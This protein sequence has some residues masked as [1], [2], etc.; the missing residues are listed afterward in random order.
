MILPLCMYYLSTHNFGQL[1]P[2]HPL[3]TQHHSFSCWMLTC[4]CY[5][6]T[7][8]SHV[9][10]A[11]LQ[12]VAA[13]PHPQAEVAMGTRPCHS[14]TAGAQVS[15]LYALLPHPA[16]SDCWLCRVAGLTVLLCFLSVLVGI[17]LLAEG[18]AA[19]VLRQIAFLVAENKRSNTICPIKIGNLFA[20]LWLHPSPSPHHKALPWLP[21]WGQ[22]A[23]QS[24]CSAP[25]SWGL[26]LPPKANTIM[27]IC[28]KLPKH[29]DFHFKV[30]SKVLLL[31]YH[32]PAE[33]GPKL[34]PT[35]GCTIPKAQLVT[36]SPQ[37]GMAQPHSSSQCQEVA[38]QEPKCCYPCQRGWSPHGP[39]AS[40][41]APYGPTGTAQASFC[42][43]E[44]TKADDRRKGG[45]E[46]KGEREKA[47]V[48]ININKTMKQQRV[49][50]ESESDKSHTTLAERLV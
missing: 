22:A 27:A 3:E 47:K 40:F 31:P 15:T 44:N 35:K 48:K 10:F 29:P 9:A 4:H 41:L 18:M 23:P 37:Q 25:W 7:Q 19:S 42:M 12:E 28:E 1:W 11:P 46:R 49:K 14:P 34:A 50:L 45:E 16:S 8:D 13:S 38:S 33:Y 24:S 26:A 39:P 30:F 43:L 36:K 20:S 21:S 17:Y 5:L 2:F 6:Y 32:R